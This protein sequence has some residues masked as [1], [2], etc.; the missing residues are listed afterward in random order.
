VPGGER[1]I[2]LSDAPARLSISH[3]RLVI[4]LEET[5]RPACS[6]AESWSE[7]TV[8]LS[9]VAVVVLS[10]PRITITQPVLDGLARHGAAVVVCDGSRLPT[11][12]LL[13]L[14]AH[15]LATQR[16][17]FQINASQPVRKRLWQGVVRAKILSQAATLD[18]CGRPGG[19]RLRQLAQGVRSGDPE[20]REGQ[21]ASV[22]WPLLFDDPNFR[23][24][25]EAEDANRLLNYGYA[26]LRAATGR[27]VCAAGLHPSIGIHHSGRSNPYVL[28]DDLMEPYRPLVDA[29]VVELVGLYGPACPLDAEAKRALISVL[30]ERL[31]AGPV[32]G[33]GG[34]RRVLECIGRTASS[35]AAAFECGDAAAAASRLW[36]PEELG[37]PPSA[38]DAA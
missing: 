19:E 23:R 15:G 33:A 17:G 36:F 7:V 12:M 27:A 35:L 9:E 26:V 10:N 30:T 18:A 11:G 8:P 37:R 6:G 31:D 34:E 25:R 1:I 3:E 29:V 32:P 16:I 20:N 28:A 14:H 38:T 4:R 5:E 2:D 13:P 22:Y 24:R 21:A